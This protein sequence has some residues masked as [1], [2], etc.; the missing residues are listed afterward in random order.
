MSSKV[1]ST[2]SLLILAQWLAAAFVLVIIGLVVSV[3]IMYVV[4]R[5]Q[6]RHT[7]RHNYPVIGRFRYMFE[8]MGEF[9]RQYFFAMDREEMPFNRA[10]RSWVYRAAKNAD[11]N[12]AFGSTRDLSRTGTIIFS[13]ARTHYHWSLLRDALFSGVVLSYFRNELR[14]VVAGCG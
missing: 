10:Q 14:C 7:I 3:G 12:V 13:N 4:D 6:N 2:D 9:M 11:R 5:T 1:F 8:R